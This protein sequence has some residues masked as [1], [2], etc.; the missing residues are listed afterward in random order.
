MPEPER[1]LVVVPTEHNGSIAVIAD[2]GEELDVPIPPSLMPGDKFEVVLRWPL[3]DR[4]VT[5]TRPRNHY[6][7]DAIRGEVAILAIGHMQG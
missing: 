5:V 6:V 1:M 3:L 2:D 7:D 4:Y